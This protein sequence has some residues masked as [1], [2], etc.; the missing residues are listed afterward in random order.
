MNKGLA[1]KDHREQQH[2][3]PDYGDAD[4]HDGKHRAIKMG[5]NVEMAA[6]AP[7]CLHINQRNLNEQAN[8]QDNVEPTPDMGPDAGRCNAEGEAPCQR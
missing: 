2:R 5:G 6:R 8:R 1:E 4:T 3:Q 7:G